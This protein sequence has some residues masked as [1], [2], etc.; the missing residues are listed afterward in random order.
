MQRSLRSLFA[1][2]KFQ[3][4]DETRCMWLENFSRSIIYGSSSRTWWRICRGICMCTWVYYSVQEKV[5]CSRVDGG[6][7][8]AKHE[9][10]ER[11]TLRYLTM[12]T[13]QQ[14]ALGI[15]DYAYSLVCSIY[16]IQ[17]FLLCFLVHSF[18][19]KKATWTN[20][21]TFLLS[22]HIRSIKKVLESHDWKKKFS[23]W[24]KFI[25]CIFVYCGSQNLEW[26]K[27]RYSI[28]SL[29]HLF[30]TFFRNYL[31]QNI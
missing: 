27:T 3:K 14:N 23:F 13:R 9:R 25:F 7:H 28:V 17:A 12:H 11:R 29:L 22:H 5:N 18:V 19:L 26:R 10:Q 16:N 6:H 4:G 30:F 31:N 1:E 8:D 21:L 24:W 15:S 20:K 2:G